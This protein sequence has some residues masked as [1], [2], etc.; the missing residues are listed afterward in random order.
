M[1]CQRPNA[2]DKLKL[3]SHD[4]VQAMRGNA[5][6]ILFLQNQIEVIH[7]RSEIGFFHG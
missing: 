4:R 5:S 2:S 1:A 6:G 7:D 3:M